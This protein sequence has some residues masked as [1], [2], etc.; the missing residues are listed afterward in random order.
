MP[1]NI[2][3]VPGFGVGYPLAGGGP[4]LFALLARP[5]HPAVK[6]IADIANIAVR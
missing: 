3:D 2:P 1:K 6:S 4:E 5:L